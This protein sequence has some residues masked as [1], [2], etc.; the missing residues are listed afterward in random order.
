MMALRSLRGL[1]REALRRERRLTLLA[2]AMWLAMLPTL[3]AWALDGHLLRGASVWLKPLKF[4]ASVGQFA[5]T[6][7]W[8]V[9]LLPA[10]RRRSLAVHLITWTITVGGTAEVAYITLQAALGQPSHY[11]RSDALHIALYAAM[12]ATALAMTATQA[13]L[14]WQIVRHGRADVQPLWR[15][16]VVTGLLMTFLLGAG[17]GA[18][19]SALQPP[20]G[21]LPVLGWHLGGDLRPAH[22]IGMHAA[23]C[24]PLLGWALLPL[25]PAQG[26]RALLLCVLAYAALWAALLALGLHGARLPVPVPGLPL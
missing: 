8:F 4:M 11:N 12:G 3:A 26:R 13:V 22:F 15:A 17:A 9:G 2:L 14:A 10:E 21:G 7:A 16:A 1:L 25:P 24:I 19:L 6:T 18:P 5:F 23:Q 20:D